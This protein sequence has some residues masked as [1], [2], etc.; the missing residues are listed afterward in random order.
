MGNCTWPWT[1]SALRPSLSGCDHQRDLADETNH[2]AQNDTFH[3]TPLFGSDELK[4]QTTPKAVTPFAG[5]ASFFVW[6]GAS[7]G[8]KGRDVVLRFSESWGGLKKH[9]SLIKGALNARN[10]IAPLLPKPPGEREILD[11]LACGG[12]A[13]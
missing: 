11:A 10:L 5:M 8:R 1:Q 9:I 6:L 13:I 2:A 12:C 4:L 3:F 7:L